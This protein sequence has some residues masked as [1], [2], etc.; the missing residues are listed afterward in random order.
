[1]ALEEPIEGSIP[2]K[3]WHTPSDFQTPGPATMKMHLKLSLSSLA[4][5]DF[6]LQWSWRSPIPPALFSALGSFSH[7]Y[8]EPVDVQTLGF[9]GDS[10][11]QQTR[12]QVKQQRVGSRHLT[13]NGSNLIGT[14]GA[15]ATRD[16]L[17]TSE[18]SSPSSLPLIPERRGEGGE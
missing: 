7:N 9:H 18:P 14:N 2:V 8:Q 1:M 16:P 15:S 17:I 13:F 4:T 6:E 11:T 5:E 12:P 3:L 10:L